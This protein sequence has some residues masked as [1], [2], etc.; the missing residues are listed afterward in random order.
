M[1]A[2]QNKNTEKLRVLIE[3]MEHDFVILQAIFQKTRSQLQELL[4][5]EAK[6]FDPDKKF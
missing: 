5:K 4:D 6:K 3:Q 1:P 2:P